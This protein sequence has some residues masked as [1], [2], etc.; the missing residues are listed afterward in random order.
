MRLHYLQHVPFENPGCILDWANT[1]NID[2]KGSHL[3]DDD[4]LPNVDD[5]DLLRDGGLRNA[6]RHLRER[7]VGRNEADSEFVSHHH[8]GE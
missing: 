4:P 2:I 8:H 1:Q 7:N 6:A 3:Y 5:F